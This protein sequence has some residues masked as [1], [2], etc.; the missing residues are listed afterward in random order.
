VQNFGPALRRV[1]K[2]LHKFGVVGRAVAYNFVPFYYYSKHGA[3]DETHLLELDQLNTF[4][5][6]T[7]RYDKPMTARRFKSILME[8]GFEIEHFWES[9]VTPLFGTAR[10]RSM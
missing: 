7:P 5:A 10:K 2:F 8:E 6:L 4:D 9:P 3:F 1:N